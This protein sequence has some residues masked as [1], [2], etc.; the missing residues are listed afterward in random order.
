MGVG[1]ADGRGLGCLWDS[2]DVDD[3]DSWKMVLG[4]ECI[5]DDDDEEFDLY[6]WAE[7]R[8]I[9][10]IVMSCVEARGKL[11]SFCV[12]LQ[13]LFRW[14]LAVVHPGVAV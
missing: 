6:R 8:R 14:F 3:A 13:V 1:E 7:H 2:G 12:V 10:F 9:Q 5:L 4:T 11:H